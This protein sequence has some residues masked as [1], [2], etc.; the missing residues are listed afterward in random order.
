[1]VAD[2][3]NGVVR[4]WDL[5]AVPRRGELL[6]VHTG[7]VWALA[8]AMLDGPPSL[9]P[10]IPTEPVWDLITRQELGTEATTLRSPAHS[11][12]RPLT[13]RWPFCPVGAAWAVKV[14][15]VVVDD[16]YSAQANPLSTD[17]NGKRAE[18]P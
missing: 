10:A 9:S 14:N 8:T 3:T 5:A 11:E 2:S 12:T 17:W 16:V 4:V 7:T 18:I 13:A 15:N 1:M 6:T